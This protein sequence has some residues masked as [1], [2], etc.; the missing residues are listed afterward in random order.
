M[1][2]LQDCI[3]LTQ[4]QYESIS[5]LGRDPRYMGGWAK[6]MNFPSWQAL[7]EGIGG[8]F[9]WVAYSGYLGTLR[10]GLEAKGVEG[11]RELHQRIVSIWERQ[12][13]SK[14]ETQPFKGASNPVVNNP[15]RP[16]PLHL[17]MVFCHLGGGWFRA[18]IDF[19]KLGQLNIG[20]KKQLKKDAK[21]ELQR[22]ASDAFLV[23][24]SRISDRR[25]WS[26]QANSFKMPVQHLPGCEPGKGRLRRQA[27][28]L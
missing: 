23:N 1:C 7:T 20:T 11:G 10:F 12:F 4:E 21:T 22:L 26:G 27:L 24:H 3:Y 16:T 5:E 19:T 9:N 8:T 15:L 25:G 17:K 13:R 6:R 14:I 2:V 18:R 28:A